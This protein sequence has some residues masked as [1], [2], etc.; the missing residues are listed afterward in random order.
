MALKLCASRSH[1]SNLRISL[2][3]VAFPQLADGIMGMSAHQATLPKQLWDKGII[4]HNMFAMCFRRELGTSK[5]GVSAGS[6]TLGGVSTSLDTGRSFTLG[7]RNYN[8]ESNFEISTNC[9]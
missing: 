2:S 8:H 7:G 1:R 3:Y 5:R 9:K 4:E 6:M